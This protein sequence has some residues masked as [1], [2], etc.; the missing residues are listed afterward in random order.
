MASTIIANPVT[1]NYNLDKYLTI[2]LKDEEGKPITGE[3]LTVKYLELAKNI[4]LMLMV[5]L[6]L[7]F[8]H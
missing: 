3:V 1:T 2:T 4:L 8:L 6:K 5:K 7:R